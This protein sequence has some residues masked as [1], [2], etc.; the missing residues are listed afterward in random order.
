[1]SNDDLIYF[2]HVLAG[3]FF[4]QLRLIISAGLL[5]ALLIAINILTFLLVVPVYMR[6][7]LHG[8][9]VRVQTWA[10]PKFSQKNEFRRFHS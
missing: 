7:V 2:L 8:C 6:P 1:M 3:I 9:C 10:V 5:F 4:G